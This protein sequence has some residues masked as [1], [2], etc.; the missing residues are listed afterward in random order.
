M[1][2]LKFSM[3]SAKFLSQLRVQVNVHNVLYTQDKGRG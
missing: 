1:F 2:S 3:E